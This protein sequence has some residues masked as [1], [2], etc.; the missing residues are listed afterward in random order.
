MA[1]VVLGLGTSHSPMLSTP[2]EV[3]PQH[4]E[5]DKRNRELWGNDGRTHDYEELLGMADPSLAKEAAPEKWQARY[6]ACQKGIARVGEVLAQ[7]A[8]DILVI[9]GDDQKELFHEDNMPTLLVYW[10]D[11]ILNIPRDR[12]RMPP[13]IAAAAW[14][15]EFDQEREFPVAS[16]LARH[17][18]EY[19]MDHDFDA[20][21]SRRLPQGRGM[22][23]AFGFVYRRIMNGKELP[24]IPIMQ[25]TYYPPNQPTPRRSFE[26]GKALRGAIESWQGDARVAVLGSGGLTHFVIDEELDRGVIKAMQEKDEQHL[27]SLPRERL[28]SGTSE[29]RNWIATAGAVEHLDMKLIDYVPCYRSPAGTGCAMGFAYWS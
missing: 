6:D 19:L 1:R 2:P 21:H 10:G 3:W 20:A 14:S 29:I 11:T 8:P 23:H 17:L 26:L 9:I 13:S 28:N 18:I 7:A 4:V 27:C 12:T 24:V 16:G 25:N 15:N 5:R 22:G